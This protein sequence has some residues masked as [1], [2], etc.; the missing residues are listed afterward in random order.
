MHSIK[1]RS[2]RIEPFGFISDQ[3]TFGSVAPNASGIALP[4][5]ATTSP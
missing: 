4:I 3:Q 2:R 5:A 1:M